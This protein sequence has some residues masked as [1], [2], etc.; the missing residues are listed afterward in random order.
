MSPDAELAAH[1]R[2]ARRVLGAWAV[3]VVSIER[4]S[5]SENIVLRVRDAEGGSHALRLHRPGYH[6]LREL[7]SEQWWTAALAGAGV[8]VPV[9]APTRRGE[10]YAP[11]ALGVGAGEWRYAGL[12]EWVDGVTLGDAIAAAL[13][14]EAPQTAQRSGRE[15]PVPRP[16]GD[17]AETGARGNAASV[18]V[19]PAIHHAAGTRPPAPAAI[20]AAAATKPAHAAALAHFASLGEIM[21]A[22]HNQASAWRIPPGFARQRLDA[23]GFMGERPFWGRFWESP[24][25]TAKQRCELTALRR[26]LAGALR[27]LGKTR[28]TYGLIHADLH[29]G[30]AIVDGE[31]LHVIDFDDAGFGWHAYEFAVALHAYQGRPR[32]ADFLAA[33]VRGYRRVRPVSDAVVAQVP[34]FLLVRTLASIGW[35]AARPEHEAGGRTAHLLALVERQ[36]EQALG[37][38]A[39]YITVPAA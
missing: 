12:L 3:D 30:N 27:K 4:V 19:S 5:V 38:R 37:E 29:P 8:D 20:P 22:I 34:M 23:D 32:F 10:G 13:A 9:V 17:P 2:A 15:L 1:L 36:V 18:Q 24:H 14:A 33:L 7:R 28:Q 35:T 31:R 6:T 25:L 39:A 21:A 26:L 16:A 11:V